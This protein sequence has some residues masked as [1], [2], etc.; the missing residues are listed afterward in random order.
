VNVRNVRMLAI[1]DE[2]V[3]VAAAHLG[4]A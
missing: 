3:T 2:A 4:L 1:D